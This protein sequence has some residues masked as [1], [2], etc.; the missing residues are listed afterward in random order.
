MDRRAVLDVYPSW[1]PKWMRFIAGMG[2]GVLLLQ[3]GLQLLD[4]R[5]EWFQGLDKYNVNWMLAMS[6]LP[7]ATVQIPHRFYTPSSHQRDQ[8]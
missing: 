4:V 1:G 7:F 5:I 8:I 6:L 2:I 3:T